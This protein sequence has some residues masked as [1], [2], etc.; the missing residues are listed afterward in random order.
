AHL[1]AQVLAVN[2]DELLPGDVSQPKEERQGGGARVVREVLGDLQVRFLQHVGR[3]DAALEAPGEPQPHHD[4]EAIAVEREK[5]IDRVLIARHGAV[6]QLDGMTFFWVH[7]GV[8]PCISAWEGPV[9]TARPTFFSGGFGGN[10]P[11][12]APG[13]QRK[14]PRCLPLLE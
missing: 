13:K 4:A 3:I 10:C 12:A 7:Y 9:S 2:D 11:A 8:P 6:E 5:L 14:R 1:S